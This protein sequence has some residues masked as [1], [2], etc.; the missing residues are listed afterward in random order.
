MSNGGS[1]T[2]LIGRA[3]LVY[4][5]W[6][7]PRLGP[8]HA[9]SAIRVDGVFEHVRASTGR[10]TGLGD[11]GILQLSGVGFRWGGI[12]SRI[13]LIVYTRGEV[14]LDLEVDDLE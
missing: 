13:A 10:A 12:G 7:A 2:T 3:L 11:V 14:T 5:A 9:A 4:A 6:L 1:E 8:A